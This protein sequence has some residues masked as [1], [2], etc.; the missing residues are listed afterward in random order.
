MPKF[1]LKSEDIDGSIATLEFDKDYLPDILYELERFLK[2]SGFHFKGTLDIVPEEDDIT[3]ET[4]N[5]FYQDTNIDLSGSWE[6]TN[7]HKDTT[8]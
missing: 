1:T 4:A 8:V 2:A 7:V 6:P 5:D 3:F